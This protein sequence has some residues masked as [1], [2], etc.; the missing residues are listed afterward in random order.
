MA[1][2]GS[3]LEE[4]APP[5]TTYRG[6]TFGDFPNPYGY[7]EDEFFKKNF[8]PHA[9]VES[10]VNGKAGQ[11]YANV[12]GLASTLGVQ[13][14]RG[15]EANAITEARQTAANQGLGRG[16][17]AQQE[18]DIRQQGTMNVTDQLM[19]AA[20]EERSRRFQLQS[21]LASS[22]IESN[23]SRYLNYL[24]KKASK[25]ASSAS[26]LGFL[27]SL[28]GGLL[29]AG[30]AIAGGLIGGP[31]GALAGGALGGA[32]GGGGQAGA[33]PANGFGNA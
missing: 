20:L 18:S 7:Q 11:D 25:A 10:L 31:V 23:K 27:G 19:G 6:E 21:M 24:Q 8:A 14:A 2:R 12:G 29:S 17:A 30:G 22:L 9:F 33:E 3:V 5:P 4:Q 26:A 32:A 28:G 13:A 1:A 16:F 15:G